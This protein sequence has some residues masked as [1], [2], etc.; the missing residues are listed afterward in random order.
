VRH[1][2][3]NCRGP[4]RIS[5]PLNI[6]AASRAALLRAYVPRGWPAT[7]RPRDISHWLPSP[8]E[9]E[10]NI[11]NY[12]QTSAWALDATLSGG[13]S[14]SSQKSVSSEPSLLVKLSSAGSSAV[15]SLS[16]SCSSGLYGVGVLLPVLNKIPPYKNKEGDSAAYESKL[17]RPNPVAMV[18]LFSTGNRIWIKPL[19]LKPIRVTP[20]EG[21]REDRLFF[22]LSKSCR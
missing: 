8:P 1:A 15:T 22:S 13:A 11:H 21:E 9:G 5:F 20:T 3:F 2:R 10:N 4:I 6:A 14:V 17:N 19:R 16:S 18:Q 7:T 12:K